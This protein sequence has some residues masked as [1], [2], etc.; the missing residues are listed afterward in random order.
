MPKNMKKLNILI[1]SLMLSVNSLAFAQDADG[2]PAGPLEFLEN[3]FNEQPPEQPDANANQ[4]QQAAPAGQQTTQTGQSNSFDLGGLD[5]F[6]QAS[7]QQQA[8]QQVSP[9]IFAPAS[10]PVQQFAPAPTTMLQGNLLPAI[11]PI[12][13]TYAP[14]P[15]PPMVAQT[16]PGALAALIPVAGYTLF[17]F[18]RKD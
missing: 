10:A 14:A 17:T 9:V 8:P 4:Q 2:P 16:G 13:Q 6:N 1:L 11:Q 15:Q 3:V 7:G 18:R 5:N 12:A